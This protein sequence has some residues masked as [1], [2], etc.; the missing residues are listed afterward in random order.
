MLLTGFMVLIVTLCVYFICEGWLKNLLNPV[1]HPPKYIHSFNPI[2]GFGLKMTKNPIEFIQSLYFHHGNVFSI[3]LASKRYVFLFDERA[4]LG[5][6]LR[7]EDLSIDEF[8]NDLNVKGLGVSR[9]LLANEFISRNQIR[10]FHRFLT[11]S[12]LQQLNA[13]VERSLIRSM[14]FDDDLTMKR[15]HFFDFFGE[16]M[17]FAGCEG[18]FGEDFTARQREGSPSFYK[19]FQDFDK[20]YKMAAMS[21]P[22]WRYFH[23]GVYKNQQ[24]FIR[25]FLSLNEFPDLSELITDRE[26]FFRDEQNQAIVSEHDVAALQAS[27]LWAAVANTGPIVCWIL[28]D[29]YLHDTALQAVISEIERYINPNESISTQ[30]SLSQM[31]T[32]DSCINETMRRVFYAISTRQAVRKTEIE[33][34]DQTKI[35]L[36]K[37]DMLVYPAF[38]K[39]FDPELFGPNPFEYQYDRFIAQNQARPPPL[40][41]F[42]CG[43]HK[44]PGRFWAINEIK[45][46]IILVLRHFSIRFINRTND[47]ENRFRQRLPFDYSKF[48]ST[49]GPT[50][51]QWAKFEIEY[52]YHGLPN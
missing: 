48:I 39:H 43:T 10:G 3:L 37:G 51:D 8:L 17:L 5:N 11:G 21:Y 31:T 29:I 6:V 12:H 13:R 4:Y 49:G 16:L 22:F 19:L 40:M 9:D 14:Q 36:R 44:C 35:G 32:L 1:A 28:F 45:I 46:L 30:Q 41:V 15:T 27:M 7:S 33:C 24:E 25:R 52:S 20:A 2:I 42:G 18:L 23:R 38:L 34:S 26:Q 50:E 47:D